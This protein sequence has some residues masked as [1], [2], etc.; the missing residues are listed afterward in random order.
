MNLLSFKAFLLSAFLLP[1]LG[2]LYKGERAKGGLLLLLVNVFLLAALFMVLRSLG[3]IL[4]AARKGGV[5]QTAELL[6]TLG[7]SSPGARWLLGGFAILWLY[8]ALDA[9]LSKPPRTDDS[10]PEE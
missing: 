1:G 10:S 2:Q 9:A 4:L 5:S 6:N 8:S 3:P 7:S